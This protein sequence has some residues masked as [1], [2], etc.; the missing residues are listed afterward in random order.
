MHIAAVGK[1]LNLKHVLFLFTDAPTQSGR[2]ERCNIQPGKT[3]HRCATAAKA[4][5]NRRR[6]LLR[7]CCECCWYRGCMHCL[8]CVCMQGGRNSFPSTLGR[9][10]SAQSRCRG[11]ACRVLHLHQPA[12]ASGTGN[13]VTTRPAAQ[14]GRYGTIVC[15]VLLGTLPLDLA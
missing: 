6:A 11:K 2:N 3:S 4:F 9:G 1:R 15:Y 10:C 5:L 12:D 14:L 8:T 13:V 7:L